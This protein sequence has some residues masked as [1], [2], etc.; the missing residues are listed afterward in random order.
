MMGQAVPVPGGPRRLSR[1]VSFI[2]IGRGTTMFCSDWSRWFIVLLRQH[3][4][5]IKNQLE[6]LKP[7]YCGLWDAMPHTRGI[8]WLLLVLYGIKV[9]FMHGKDLLWASLSAGGATL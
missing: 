5:A 9:A 3:S 2:L 1:S 4:Y 7:P 8:S 6:A